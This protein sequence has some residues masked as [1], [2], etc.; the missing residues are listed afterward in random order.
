[1]EVESLFTNLEQNNREK[2][3]N[4]YHGVSNGIS[5]F[6]ERAIHNTGLSRSAMARM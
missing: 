1:M 5:E 4:V 6:R 3:F 2:F